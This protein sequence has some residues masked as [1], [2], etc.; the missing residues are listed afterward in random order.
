MPHIPGHAEQDPNRPLDVNEEL[1]FTQSQR[2]SGQDLSLLTNRAKRALI[3]TG[4]PTRAGQTVPQSPRQRQ[5]GLLELA[6]TGIGAAS[7]RAQSIQST[8]LDLFLG[9]STQETTEQRLLRED[10]RQRGTAVPQPTALTE[11]GGVVAGGGISTLQEA[12]GGAGQPSDAGVGGI[13]VEDIPGIGKVVTLADGSQT[14]IP[15]GTSAQEAREFARITAEGERGFQTGLAEQSRQFTAR[16]SELGRQGDLQLALLPILQQLLQIQSSPGSRLRF[17]AS[18]AGEGGG[19]GFDVTRQLAEL[20]GTGNVGGVGSE[21]TVGGQ[22]GG[23]TT[24][25]NISELQQL[26]G[27]NLEELSALF[28]ILFPGQDFFDLTQQ[29]QELAPPGGGGGRPFRSTIRR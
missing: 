21:I 16:Q 1:A 24:I 2:R 20:F 28:E 8:L 11:G 9:S 26:S 6:G 13:T 12:V 18:Q 22:D 19:I 7:Q 10:V 3:R 29:A 15:A 23:P 25:P 14:I 4:T 27:G 5:G 17:A